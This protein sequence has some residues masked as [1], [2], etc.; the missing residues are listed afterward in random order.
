MHD[1]R[2]L[3]ES[4][5]PTGLPLKFG[6]ASTAKRPPS[7]TD[8]HREARLETAGRLLCRPPQTQRRTPP[9]PTTRCRARS[10][11]T[12]TVLYARLIVENTEPEST[13][14]LNSSSGRRSTTAPRAGGGGSPNGCA[15]PAAPFARLCR[16]V[17]H[18]GAGG[19][20]DEG[21]THGAGVVRPLGVTD[22]QLAIRDNAALKSLANTLLDDATS[23]GRCA[24][25]DRHGR[26]AVFQLL[27]PA[28]Q[29][30]AGP[31]RHRGSLHG[32]AGSGWTPCNIFVVSIVCFVLLAPGGMIFVLRQNQLQLRAAR[33]ATGQQ[34]AQHLEQ[35][36]ATD[37]RTAGRPQQP[38][39]RS[40]RGEGGYIGIF[41]TMFGIHR[42]D[43]RLA[44]LVSLRDGR[45][46][47]LKKEYARVRRQPRAWR[48]STAI[49]TRRSATLPRLSRISTAVGQGG[50]H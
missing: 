40:Q 23:S 20:P 4:R 30:R 8:R 37:Q 29:G 13:T 43:H 44:A 32:P 36:P 17:V 6:V 38:D 42:Q 27:A 1:A 19:G 47:E 25:C 45:I 33:T 46:D 18:A 12:L 3:D 28:P 35:R 14:H 21:H 48:S 39:F 24:T 34:P 41:L 22:I 15:N 50:T 31:A 2:R 26:R 7:A 16:G 9:T 5:D 49:S 10:R 11:G